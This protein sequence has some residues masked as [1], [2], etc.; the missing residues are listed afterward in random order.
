MFGKTSEATTLNKAR[1]AD[2]RATAALHVSTALGGNGF[3]GLHPNCSSSDCHGRLRMSAV[4]S[5]W[6]KRRVHGD[7][8]HVPGP[9][10]QRIGRV[11]SSLIAVAAAFYD[12]A[13]IIFASKVHGCR[14]VV[15][16]SR[17]D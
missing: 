4:A 1:H 16:V 14:N 17:R 13:Q 12:Q 8:I 10:Q 15:G 3:V 7:V 5:L 6:N 9:N 2:C 11:R